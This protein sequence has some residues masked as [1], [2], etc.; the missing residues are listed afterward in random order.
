MTVLEVTLKLLL[1]VALGGLIG[2]ERETSKKPAGF[3][4]NILICVG[5]TMVMAL[6]GLILQGNGNESTR[7]AAGVITGIGFIGAGTIIQ[8]RGSILGLTTAATLWAVAGLGLVIGTGHY[9]IAIIFTAIIVLTLVIFRQFE[10]QFLKKSLYHYHLKLKDSREALT[11]LRSLAFHEG[12]KFQEFTL[13][14]EKTYALVDLSFPA[15]EEK[16]NKFNQDLLGLEGIL[17]LKIE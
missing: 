8:A 11:T 10:G 14:K 12:I 1:A 2:L 17:E 4:T 16:E 7:I 15:P 13:K 9:L 5:S 3:R 6:S